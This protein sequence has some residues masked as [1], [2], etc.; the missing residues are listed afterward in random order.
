MSDPRQMK[1]IP[2]LGL[3]FGKLT[4]IQLIYRPNGRLERDVIVR[5]EC[6]HVKTVRFRNMVEGKSKS[7]AKGQCHYK[8]NK[9]E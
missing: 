9:K 3:R 4:V 6:G 8:H 1:D 7:C 2:E 5:C